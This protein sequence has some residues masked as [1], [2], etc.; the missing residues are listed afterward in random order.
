MTGFRGKRGQLVVP[1]SR[2]VRR[3]TPEVGQEP[4]R[5]NFH[6]FVDITTLL[7][8]IATVVALAFLIHDR[9]DQANIAAW[10]L[11]QAY[12]QQQPRAQFNEGQSFALETLAQHEVLLAGIDAHDATIE[13]A[14]LDGL[15]APEA[16]F[17]NASLS[18]IRLSEADLSASNLENVMI[19]DCK[20]QNTMFL[21]ANLRNG[22]IAYSNLQ[23]AFF[24]GAD[25]SDFKADGV[26]FLT[27]AENIAAG[28]TP[29]RPKGGMYDR[30]VLRD[31]CYRPGHP[32]KAVGADLP[33]DPQGG[34]CM[35]R[36]GKEWAALEPHHQR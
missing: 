11:L 36:W 21:D 25:V 8:S 3:Q 10:T 14:D 15:L 35:T 6:W 27:V 22:H 33:T 34:R 4:R 16:S 29:F 7:A 19:S 30:D 18:E 2:R 32:P 24:A 23:G 20:C 31:S 5:L 12:L 9:R 13:E 17:K 26:H 1:P 28:R